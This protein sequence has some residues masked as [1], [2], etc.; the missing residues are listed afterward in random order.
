LA[1]L[2]LAGCAHAA[3]VVTTTCLPL[4][5]YGPEAQTA[6]AAEVAALPPGSALIGA[7]LDLQRMRDAD[8]ACLASAP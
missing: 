6:L 4:T 8:R 7:M 2:L 3:P 1:C 5:V